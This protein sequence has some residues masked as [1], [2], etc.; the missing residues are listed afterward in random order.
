MG[1]LSMREAYACALTDY[2]GANP[3]IMAVDVDT[4]ASTLTSIFAARYPERFVNVGIAEPCAV[5]V[6]AG[7][8]LGGMTPS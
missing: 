1:E 8:A 2:A 6:S 4:S 5:D 3:R 7:L